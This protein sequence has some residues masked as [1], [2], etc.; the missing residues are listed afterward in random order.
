[1]QGRPW[2]AFTNLCACDWATSLCRIEFPELP[3]LHSADVHGDNDKF[4]VVTT[5]AA[6]VHR[7]LE[8]TRA[9]CDRNGEGLLRSTEGVSSVDHSEAALLDHDEKLSSS[10]L[11]TTGQQALPRPDT[12]V[13]NNIP[14]GKADESGRS[15]SATNMDRETTSSCPSGKGMENQDLT[16]TQ[17]GQGP[18]KGVPRLRDVN[19]GGDA[20][21]PIIRKPLVGERQSS[22]TVNLGSNP[23]VPE[24]GQP[25]HHIPTHVPFAFK[26]PIS[27]EPS[28]RPIINHPIFAATQRQE[29]PSLDPPRGMDRLRI[30]RVPEMASR[31]RVS[32]DLGSQRKSC[33][34]ASGIPMGST[35]ESFLTEKLDTPETSGRASCVTFVTVATGE[36]SP[37]VGQSR[38]WRGTTD[39]ETSGATS[40]SQ[41][42]RNLS[43]TCGEAWTNSNPTKAEPWVDSRKSRSMDGRIPN[44]QCSRPEENDGGS[45]LSQVRLEAASV[46]EEG[47]SHPV[48]ARV[49]DAAP[50]PVATAQVESSFQGWPAES[51]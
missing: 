39:G 14:L 4:I 40:V 1:V 49:A 37:N 5:R 28:G 45:L 25:G 23:L 24:Q 47:G 34:S 16:E 21:G 41:T 32:F 19:T 20:E 13:S 27:G 18:R 36:T 10:C 44:H 8:T 50:L 12:Q 15:I 2:T 42:G 22:E 48:D 17:P 30:S 35:A 46:C 29:A 33:M 51:P 11:P 7:N 9:E 6:D 38:I 43:E 3:V 31:R 26:T